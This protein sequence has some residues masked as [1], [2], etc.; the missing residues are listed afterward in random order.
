MVHNRYLTSHPETLVLA[1]AH[2][3]FHGIEEAEIQSVLPFFKLV[4]LG[5]REIFMEEGLE[6][7]KDLYLILI[8]D[9]EV[10][11]KA[12]DIDNQVISEEIDDQFIIANL[13]AGDA[14]GELSFIKGDPRSA[15]IRS[16]TAA[17]LLGL[18]PD[19]LVK[20]ENRFP[21][22]ANRMMKNMI[23]YVGD[24]LSKTSTNEVKALKIDLQH[25]ILTSKANLF[26]LMSLVFCVF[27][28]LRSIRSAI[29]P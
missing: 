22:T 14:I 21:R 27:T 11:K 9:L 29:Y 15:S 17:V 7:S 4:T 18:N 28:T 20:L 23:G 6:S 26:S 3:F 19:E 12:I 5:P 1:K 25:S 8:G 13:T 16:V 2:P 24:R 10:I